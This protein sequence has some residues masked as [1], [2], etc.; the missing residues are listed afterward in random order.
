MVD[1]ARR[2]G[3][4]LG[5]DYSYR[6][7]DGMRALREMVARGELGRV[8]AVD[9]VFHNAYGPDKAWCRDPRLAGGGALMDLGVH[10]VDLALWVLDDAPRSAMRAVH[11][12]VCERTWGRPP[13]LRATLHPRATGSRCALPSRDER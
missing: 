8:F 6:F 11:G 12:A 13:V 3:R 7:T 9:A 5:V 2:A 1:A 10:L 4:R